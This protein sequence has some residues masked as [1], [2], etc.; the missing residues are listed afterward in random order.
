MTTPLR[1]AIPPWHPFSLAIRWRGLLLALIIGMLFGLL[2]PGT[3]HAQASSSPAEQALPSTQQL[4]DLLE[5]EA[6]RQALITQLRS[7]ANSADPAAAAAP[8]SQATPDLTDDLARFL[9][10]LGQELNVAIETFRSLGSGEPAPGITAEIWRKVLTAFAIVAAITL[11]SWA[12]LRWLAGFYY[13]RIDRK[14]AQAPPVPPGDTARALKRT[15]YRNITAIA[16]A[17]ALDLAVIALATFAGYIASL[18]LVGEPAKIGQLENRFLQTFLATEAAKA[19]VRLIFA[20]RYPHLRLLNMPDAEATFWNNWLERLITISSYSLLIAVP[21]VKIMFS[22]AVG[23]MLGLIIMLGVYIY[24][25]RVV[26]TNRLL[27]RNRLMQ[28]AERTSAFFGTLLRMLA[29]VW[30]LLAIA[31]FTVLLG[32]SQLAPDLALPFMVRATVQSLVAIGIAL[33]LS[34]TLTQVASRRIQLPAAWR[35]HLPLLERHLNA[36]VPATLKGLRLLLLLFASLVVLDA[37]QVFDLGANLTSD[38]GRAAIFMVV[39]I[40]IVLLIATAS[41]T[42]VASVI[43][44]RLSMSGTAP[45]MPSAR[46]RTLLTLF[47]NAT[48]I[49]IV[50]MTVLVLLAQIGIDIGPLIAGAGVV[51]LAIGFGAQKLVQ[52]IITGVFIQIE[53]GMNQNDIVEVAGVFGTV[54]KLTIRSVG[55][56]TLDGAYHLVPFSSVDTVVNHMRD[57]SYHVG[58]YTIAHRENVDDAVMHLK[59]AY[60]ELEQDEIL[61]PELMNEMTVAG[62]TSLSERG[63]TIR[64]LIKTTPGM[65]FAVQRG[66]NR[67]VK[68]HFDA[69]RIELPYPHRVLYF[70]Q[71]KNGNSPAMKLQQSEIVDDV[72][73]GQADAPG[74]T[75]PPGKPASVASNKNGPTADKAAESGGADNPDAQV[76]IPRSS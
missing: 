40:G 22:P 49:V 69:A 53:N 57:F 6:S 24:A 43:E 11:V 54:E 73:P 68:K 35:T 41:W 7:H 61:A 48:M 44:H 62:V 45:G 56:R 21:L 26:W 10:T 59:A 23:Q 64:V 14:L 19:L 75:P 5:N 16:G 72:A 74:Q 42:I 70:G 65:Q 46:E 25:L 58:E 3:G 12:L 33:A 38:R 76:D 51:G 39:R 34:A 13:A 31:Y 52:D 37:W 29:R 50:T 4:A 27:L 18:W 20:T 66:Y 1:H 30:H 32:A 28:R 55:I 47:R 67:L 15:R 2:A 8:G 63:V 71:D 60:A 17:L 36:Y 9:S